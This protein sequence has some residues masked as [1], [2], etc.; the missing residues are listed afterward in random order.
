[1][2][3]YGCSREDTEQQ[4]GVAGLSRHFDCWRSHP[5]YC[6]IALQDQSNRGYVW[7]TK[8]RAYGALAMLYICMYTYICVVCVRV[9]LCVCLCVCVFVC[10]YQHNADVCN[11]DDSLVLLQE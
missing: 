8:T 6:S 10:V 1:M 5:W 4:E 2:H 3:D 7:Q 11:S 9:C